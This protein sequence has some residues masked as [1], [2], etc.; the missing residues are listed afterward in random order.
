[1][2]SQQGEPGTPGQTGATGTPGATGATGA[3][4][5]TGAAG[6]EGHPGSAGIPGPAGPRGPE[7]GATPALAATLGELA[8][9]VDKLGLRSLINGVTTAINALAVVLLI[10]VLLQLSDTAANTNR[11]LSAVESVTGPE[12]RANSAAN[13]ERLVDGLITSVRRSVD[14]S[15][16]YFHEEATPPACA[17]VVARLEALRAGGDPF[18]RSAP[19][20]TTIRP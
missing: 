3:S 15:G 9:A 7:G 13:T 12:A 4:G 10:V 2:V 14:C 16:F 11:I 19:T 20:T 18:A 8:R 5:A 1:V 17:E 6:V